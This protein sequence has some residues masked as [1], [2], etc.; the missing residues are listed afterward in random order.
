MQAQA[1]GSGK[2]CFLEAGKPIVTKTNLEGRITYANDS[3]VRISGFTREELVGSHHNIVR[4][5]DMPKEAFADLWR[6]IK[7]GNPWRGLVKNRTKDGDYYWV[8]AFVTPLTE[9]GRIVGY[10]SVRSTP[11]RADVEAT[12]TLYAAVRAGRDRFP[13]T[14]SPSPLSRLRSGVFGLCGAIAVAGSVV[15]VLAGGIP[16]LL[17]GA[18]AVLAVVLGGRLELAL[19]RPLGRVSEALLQIDEGRLDQRISLGGG[20]PAIAGQLEATRIH[21]R[22]MFADVLVSTRDVDSGAE[23]LEQSMA[24]LAQEA[25]VQRERI[26][27][28][29]AA[30]EQM[31]VS[32]NEISG[33]TQSS[34]D[35]A[36]QTETQ[37]VSGIDS[38]EAGATLSGEAVNTVEESRRRLEEVAASIRQISGVSQ[39]IKDIADQT[40]LLALNAAIEA[41]R[42]GDTGRG[43][44][45]VADE[46]RTLA[47]RTANSTLDIGKLVS[48]ISRQSELAVDAM[49]KAVEQVARTRGSFD[50]SGD[51]LR[52]IHD[53]ST[54]AAHFAREIASMLEQQSSASHE[55]A[56]AL[57]GFTVSIDSSSNSIAGVGDAARQLNHT[58]GELRLLVRHLEQ[59]IGG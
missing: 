55:I 25:Q 28:I 29:A 15:A 38:V 26:M 20:L 22:A 1:S 9:N 48:E 6:V 36:G 43:F 31:S 58:A 4:H 2:E 50:G 35:A 27:Q 18:V 39:I 59:S 5:P 8:E 3:F 19:F 41:A 11:A 7:Q 16:A 42:A 14:P 47:E 13:A 53:A 51:R 56:I 57:E 33:N 12:E 44:A 37:A 52:Q 40:N 17:G 49:H 54:R 32:I 21:L 24:A 46:V 30:M 34:L 10:M 45:V 23:N